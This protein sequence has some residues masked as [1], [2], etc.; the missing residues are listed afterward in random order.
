MGAQTHRI[1]INMQTFNLDPV[2]LA[3]AS[4]PG[5]KPYPP[6][7]PDPDPKP[8]PDPEPEPGFGPDV[9]P[10]KEPEPEDVPDVTPPS[11]EPLHAL[12]YTNEVI[13]AD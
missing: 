11:P 6:V 4:A 13:A 9:V 8:R 3:K 5:E 1:Q 2:L 7:T 10:V 12:R